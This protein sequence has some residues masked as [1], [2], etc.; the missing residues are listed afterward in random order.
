ML[1]SLHAREPLFQSWQIFAS[2][3]QADRPCAPGG[4]FDESFCFKRK[5]HLMHSGRCNSE[6]PPYVGLRRRT[7][8][9]L[10]IVVN[11]RQILTLLWSKMNS[12]FLVLPE[13]MRRVIYQCEV[14][15]IT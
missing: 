8:I 12:Q 9:K 2:N 3:H 1:L 13:Q 14:R 7:V 10:G 11:E 15:E 4:S 5:H 6:V